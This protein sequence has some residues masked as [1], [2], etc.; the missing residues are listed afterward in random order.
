M[1]KM[2]NDV[3]Y[4]FRSMV[5]SSADRF[6]EKD[7]LVYKRGGGLESVTFE[8]FEERV[9]ALSEAFL[10][11][12]LGGAS[13]AVI[14]ET[15]PEWIITYVATIII[16]GVIVPLDKELSAEAV[17]GFINKVGCKAVVYG[18]K[19][20]SHFEGDFDELSSLEYKIPF[21]PSVTE[22]SASRPEKGVVPFLQMLGFGRGLVANGCERYDAIPV[23][24]EKVCAIL[25]TSGTTGSSKGV[26]LCQKNIIHA[27]NASYRVTGF[28]ASDTVVSVLPIH[29]TYEMTCGILTPLFIGA[30]VCI[31]DSL[32]YIV[33][34]FQLFRPTGLV[35]V[36]LFVSTIYKRIW[37]TA[38][39]GNKEKILRNS[40]AVS[41]ALRKV[42]VDTRKILF[43]SVREVFGGR[44][45]RIICGG[46]PMPP[47]LVAEFEAFGINLCQGYGITECAPLL[48]VCPEDD[49][50][51]GSVGP[52]IPGVQVKIDV[53]E[54]EDGKEIGEI[55]VKGPNIM[56]GY[57]E[58]RTATEE[59]L[60]GAWF[61][62]GDYGYL[63]KD[64]FIFITGRKKNVI[65]LNNGKNVFPEEI[66]EYLY[67]FDLVAECVV[68]GRKND[69]DN[70]VVT[71]LIYPDFAKA[72]EM[73]LGTDLNAIGGV[74]KEK[75]AELNRS[76]P[77]FKQVRGLELR[78]N[79]FEKNT[80]KKI[81]R[82][83][84][85]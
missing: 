72:E 26:M 12:G 65:V 83:K 16:G 34:N 30:T 75:L 46:A 32:K 80:S 31:N 64:G 78:R 37:D 53:E 22:S 45:K 58:D 21:D 23:D 1:K 5:A 29:H 6:S 35:L 67:K 47:D 55:L 68:I 18:H 76:L 17:R 9:R 25:F 4:D 10:E 41:N 84:I 73:G 51:P 2:T 39:K 33:R 42:K 20:A 60:S 57:F 11:L 15:S 71:A 69:D 50:R 49:N 28:E 52:P 70:V 79:E 3:A 63:D 77:S 27:I 19:F 74:I 66:E 59:V 13:I 7:Y 40:I 24:M 54:V 44:I 48:S 62:T 85:K 82:Y 36:P 56:K 81:I 14:G 8:G 38:R 43:K 61:R